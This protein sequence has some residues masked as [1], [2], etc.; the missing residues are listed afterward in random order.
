MNHDPSTTQESIY[1]VPNEVSPE[2]ITRSLQALLPTRHRPIA[3]HRFTVLDT[4]DGR[5]RRAG[6][7]LTRGTER[8]AFAV[9]WQTRGWGSHMAIRLRQPVSFAWELPA[10]PFQQTLAAV[11][12]VRRLLAQTDA[13]EH[14]SLLD[15]LDGRDKTV[16][17]LRV[18]SCQARLPLSRGAWQ[19]LPT[20]VTLTGLRGYEQAFER[21]VPVIESRPGLESCREGPLDVMLRSVGAPIRGDLSSPRVDLTPDVRADVG[22]RQI[23]TALLGI[24]AANEPGLR[25][26]LDT[27]FLH[28]FRVAIRRTR[29]LLGQIRHVFPPEA[30][31]HFSTEFSWLGRLTGPPRDLDVLVLSLR[32]RLEE[33]AAADLD[34]LLALL[35][36]AQ[37]REHDGLAQA[38]DS[39]R[40][41]RLLSDWKAFLERPTASDPEVRDADR[42]LAAVV[43]RRAWKLSRRIA[44]RGRT[45]DEHARPECLHEVRVDAKKLRYLIDVMPAFCDATDLD[46][47][48]GALKKL[49]RVLGDFNDAHVQ[50]ERLLECGRA[51]SASGGSGAVLLALGRLAEQSRQRR[52]RLRAEVVERMARFGAHRPRAACRRAFHKGA[53]H[54]R[55][56]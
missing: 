24:L 46:C 6:A 39:E 9:V 42:P 8:D 3:R 32:G 45:L 19:R 20:I 5:I 11:I 29:S 40:Y 4:F 38:L 51:V 1:I 28:D 2:G 43:S 50:E 53:L 36:E 13:E 25:A 22:A 7:C 54:E 16:A 35:S 12:G 34:Q 17:R 30:V 41:R 47:I 49:Q 37:Q 31:Q 10:G 14:G 33:F 18:A 23:H 44:K 27:E 56:R 52:E 48:L 15:I 55:K 21:L 26:R